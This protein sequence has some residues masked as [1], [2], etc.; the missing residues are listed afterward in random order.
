MTL[1]VAQKLRG[2]AWALGFSMQ[3]TVGCVLQNPRLVFLH[4]DTLESR[5]GLLARWKGG[6][7]KA[8]VEML[9]QQ[10][11]LLLCKSQDLAL[12]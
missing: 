8:A 9:L 10:P 6:S 12:R 3:T 7:R 4:P 5:V 1:E 2:L 11:A